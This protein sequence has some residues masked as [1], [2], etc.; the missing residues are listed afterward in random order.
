MNAF[1]NKMA[2]GSSKGV[3]ART[4]VQ[5]TQVYN[6]TFYISTVDEITKLSE[7]F[8]QAITFRLNYKWYSVRKYLGVY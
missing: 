5:E 3:R 2:Y 1:R 4:K 8:S 7:C 6:L